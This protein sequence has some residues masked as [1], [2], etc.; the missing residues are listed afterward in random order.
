[1]VRLPSRLTVTRPTSQQHLQVLRHRR[2]PQLEGVGDLVD[3]SLL[4]GDELQDVSATGFSDGVE[5]IR[6]RRGAR[7]GSVIYSHMGICQVEGIGALQRQQPGFDV[8]PSGKPRQLAR[9]SDDAMARRHDRHGIPSVGRADGAHGSRTADLPCDLSVGSRL[10]E[11][12]REQR[13]PHLALKGGSGQIQCQGERLSPPGE[14][15]ARAG[16]RPRRAPDACR[17]RRRSSAARG[18]ADRSPTGWRRGLRCSPP[19]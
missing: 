7:H 3:R 1:M 19:A 9:R 4:G 8:E 6:R 10:A 18:P 11:R 14:V 2:L 5:R 13:V 17:P 16:A 12:D 15:F